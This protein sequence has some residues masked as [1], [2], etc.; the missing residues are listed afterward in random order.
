VDRD[1]VA[2]REVRERPDRIPDGGVDRR[3]T[4][5]EREVV[6]WREGDTLRPERAPEADGR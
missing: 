2:V 6:G 4:L 3:P 1:G 5:R